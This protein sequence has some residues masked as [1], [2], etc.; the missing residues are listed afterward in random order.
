MSMPA[1]CQRLRQCRKSEPP[2]QFELQEEPEQIPH[3]LRFGG[4]SGGKRLYVECS[5]E[6]LR[7]LLRHL[8]PNGLMLDIEG[9]VDRRE[10][11]KVT[12][13]LSGR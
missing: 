13:I 7:T 9:C 5:V 8:S 6:E 11:E 3:V 4:Q 2:C 10:A 1:P 12:A